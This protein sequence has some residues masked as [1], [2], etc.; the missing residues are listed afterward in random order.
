MPAANISRSAAAT[1][2][3]PWP[4]HTVNLSH[5]KPIGLIARKMVWKNLP[6]KPASRAELL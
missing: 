6:V 2:R 5:A 4:E 1:L 3:R